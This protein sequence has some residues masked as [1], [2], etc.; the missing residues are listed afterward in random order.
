MTDSKQEMAERMAR[1]EGL[2]RKTSSM[3][4]EVFN[5]PFEDFAQTLRL[6]VCEALAAYD[7]SR[8]QMTE[9]AFVFSC[10]RNRV[11]DFLRKLQVRSEAGWQEPALIEDIAPSE[12][13]HRDGRHSGPRDKWEFQFCSTS[14]EDAF[15]ILLSEIPLIPST[16]DDQERR[17][18]G[19]L[20]VGFNQEEVA[21][22]LGMTR[23]AA[24]TAVK[25]IRTKLADWNP[26]EMEPQSD[27]ALV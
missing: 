3:Y 21:Q 10:V 8:S 6:K 16:L 26:A 2:V 20:Y 5:E 4:Y 13:E 17:I 12:S 1:Y 25:Q 22:E 14:E 23:S 7:T 11:K 9:K 18:V 19:L 24:I 27:R 15:A